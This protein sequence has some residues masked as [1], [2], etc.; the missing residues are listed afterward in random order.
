MRNSPA[1]HV[2]A[3]AQCGVCPVAS[4]RFEPGQD[5]NVGQNC[6]RECKRACPRNAAQ[7]VR[8]PVVDDA[9]HQFVSFVWYVV[10]LDNFADSDAGRC[11]DIYPSTVNIVEILKSLI[12]D[13]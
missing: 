5:N 13:V 4:H 12:I 2:E 7:Y 1:G 3:P 6:A 8:H 9:V 11:I 10:L